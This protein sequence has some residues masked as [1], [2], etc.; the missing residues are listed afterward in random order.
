MEQTL[1]EKEWMEQIMNFSQ[2]AKSKSLL[3]L[4]KVSHIHLSYSLHRNPYLICEVQS[5]NGSIS[6]Q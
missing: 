4:K 6:T 2:I 3:R 1:A 5:Q